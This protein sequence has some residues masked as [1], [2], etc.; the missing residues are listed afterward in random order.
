MRKSRS[1]KTIITEIAESL[2]WG[3]DFDEQKN[4]RTS[5]IE[6]YV[7][8]SQYSPAGQDFSFCVWYD[9]LGEIPRKVFDYWQDYDIDE[10]VKMWLEAKANGVGGVPC[11]RVLVHDQEDIQNMIYDLWSALREHVKG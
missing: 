9:K 7:E 6:R 4:A 5:K 10:E 8:F 1:K 2:G 11:A 3:A